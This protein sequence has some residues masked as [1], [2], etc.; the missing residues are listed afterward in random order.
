M[1]AGRILWVLLSV[2]V[3][4]CGVA[5]RGVGPTGGRDAA[6]LGAI[7]ADVMTSSKAN[8]KFSQALDIVVAGL[9]SLQKDLNSAKPKSETAK[10]A[11]QLRVILQVDRQT[12]LDESSLAGLSKKLAD[13]LAMPW[14]TNNQRNSFKSSLTKM[15]KAHF[16]PDGTLKTEA[17]ARERFKTEVSKWLGYLQLAWEHAPQQ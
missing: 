15:S 1:R 13:L 14:L 12:P 3:V 5:Q 9:K 16:K 11:S 7:G 10:L 2:A 17:G 8:P 6:M 4:G